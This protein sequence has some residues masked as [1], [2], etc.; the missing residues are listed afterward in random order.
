MCEPYYTNSGVIFLFWH[1]SDCILSTSD[2]SVM[3]DIL[4]KEDSELCEGMVI[5]LFDVQYSITKL[6][7]HTNPG[8]VVES[9]EG[10]IGTKY[11]YSLVLNIS[12]NTID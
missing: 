9:S 5:N 12:L 6:N 2:F 10:M 1:G 3:R 7:T 4:L 11:R 8:T